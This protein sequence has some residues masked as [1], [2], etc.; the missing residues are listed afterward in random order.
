[1]RRASELRVLRRIRFRVKGN[2]R[3]NALPFD[4]L[5][6][7]RDA[8]FGPVEGVISDLSKPLLDRGCGVAVMTEN[9]RPRTRTPGCAARKTVMRDR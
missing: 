9:R 7:A 3:Y 6:A 8:L 1:M 4:A 2:N 5:F